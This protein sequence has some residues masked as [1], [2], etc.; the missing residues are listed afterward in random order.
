MIWFLPT[1]LSWSS[2]TTLL[3]L[4]HQI[5]AI[6]DI[7]SFLKIIKLFFISGPLPL[8]YMFTIRKNKKPEKLKSR[9]HKEK[10]VSLDY[11]IMLSKLWEMVTDREA[12]CAAVHGVA[13]HWTQLSS[14]MTFK[15]HS[16]S[17]ELLPPTPPAPLPSRAQSCGSLDSKNISSFFSLLNML[18]AG[19]NDNE[20]TLSFK[21][22]YNKDSMLI[23]CVCI[24]INIYIFKLTLGFG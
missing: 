8:L 10:F 2:C 12:W 9:I 24:C 11:I 4:G 16:F 13:K 21:K 20:E 7:F 5:Q 23:F 17:M 15:F 1:F 18:Q 19:F 22:L 3:L 14:W 6:L